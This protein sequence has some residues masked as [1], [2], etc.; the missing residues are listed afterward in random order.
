LTSEREEDTHLP[1]PSWDLWEERRGT[2]LYTTA[3]IVAALREAAWLGRELGDEA[4]A[5]LFEAAS[6]ETRAAL[7]QY[8][9]DEQK[10]TLVRML[11]RDDEGN[12]VS[13][14]TVDASAYAVFA[15][16]V[17]DPDNPRVRATMEAIGRRLWVRTG[18]GGLARYERDY[19]FR[20][21]EDFTNIPGNPWIICTL[22][23]AEWTIATAKKVDDLRPALDMIEWA[24]ICT[25]PAGIL[26]EQIHPV[27]Y[28]PLSVTPLTWS[29]AQLVITTLNYLD[30]LQTF[31]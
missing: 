9:W 1:L 4:N 31:S 6:E 30:K 16:G 22:W 3:M 10:K 2:H 14:V 28:E 18:I 29:H 19:Y 13:D 21:S 5:A 23:L 17:L 25:L 20:V 8:F 27:S 11:S 15:F 12:L 7:E 24:T 26:P